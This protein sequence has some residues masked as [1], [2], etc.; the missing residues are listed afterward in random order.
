MPRF[1][2]VANTQKPVLYLDFQGEPSRQLFANLLTGNPK[3]TSVPKLLVASDEFK[4]RLHLLDVVGDKVYEPKAFFNDI[5]T[6]QHFL[7]LPGRIEDRISIYLYTKHLAQ[8]DKVPLL[9]SDLDK[10]A[11]YLYD[12][13]EVRTYKGDERLN[14]GV[15][16]KAHRVCRFCGKSMPDV[17]FKEKAHAISEALG[18]K[19]LVCREECDECN[20]RFNETIEQDVIKLF[21]VQLLLLGVKGKNGTPTIKSEN[22]SITKDTSSRETLGRD[23]LVLKVKDMPDTHDLKEMVSFLSQKIVLQDSFFIPQNIYKC[24]CKYALALVDS[25]YLKYFKD[26]ISW[27]NEPV[28]RHRLPPVW[29]YK[30]DM[31]GTPSM[32]IMQR[33]H[34]HKDIPYCWAIL[35]IAGEQFLFIIPFCSLDKYKFIGKSRRSFFINGLKEFMPISL[36]PVRF[37]GVKPQKLMMDMN[38]VISPDC[39][40]GRDYYFI[41]PKTHQRL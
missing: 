40:E 37:D 21:H 22:V 16:N 30:V 41:D 31:G 29:H 2:I 19:G 7:F 10:I 20:R 39:V 36:E 8:I 24:F 35:N 11:P 5:P 34:N 27:I 15:Y 32:V 14:I 12:H 28:S 3:S 23:T 4:D 26:T 18:N 13:Y 33:K 1:T 25:R 6:G 17:T 9:F 38:I